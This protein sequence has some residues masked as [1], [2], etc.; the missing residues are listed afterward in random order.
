MASEY[1]ADHKFGMAVPEGGSNCEKCEYL[2]GSQKCGNE[3]F[4][5]S[6]KVPNKAAGSDKIPVKTSRFCCD[7]FEAG[8]P[9]ARENFYG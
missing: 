8:K 5:R 4:I 1:P 2:A 9:K 6:A 3:Y 7:V